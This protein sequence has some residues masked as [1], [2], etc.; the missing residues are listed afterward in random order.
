MAALPKGAGRGS[1][2]LSLKDIARAWMDDV[3]E[4]CNVAHY[5]DDL[6]RGLSRNLALYGTGRIPDVADGQVI[7]AVLREQA[8]EGYP[9]REVIKGL[10][11]SRI[12]LER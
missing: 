6:L 1:G 12:F 4:L 11:R 7:E 2:R 9:L 10:V 5:L 3:H 8:A